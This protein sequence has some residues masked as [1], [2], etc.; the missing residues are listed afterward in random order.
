MSYFSRNLVMRYVAIL[1]YQA[2]VRD[3]NDLWPPR[4]IWKKITAAVSFSMRE[5]VRSG[6]FQPPEIGGGKPP[7]PVAQRMPSR[8]ARLG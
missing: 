3:V 1:C 6:G 5:A 8:T 7:L 4:F 2:R